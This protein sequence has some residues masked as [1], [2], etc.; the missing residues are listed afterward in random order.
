MN[1][2]RE[3][4]YRTLGLFGNATEKE[5]ASL[6]YNAKEKWFTYEPLISI[7]EGLNVVN[8]SHS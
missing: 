2:V 1:A 5:F 7:C 4:P 3:N 8:T 6:F